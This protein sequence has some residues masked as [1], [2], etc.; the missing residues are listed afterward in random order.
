MSTLPCLPHQTLLLSAPNHTQVLTYTAITALSG[1]L[2]MRSP[3]NKRSVTS[4]CRPRILV[5]PSYVSASRIN[6]FSGGCGSEQIQ[7]HLKRWS[8][9]QLDVSSK[10]PGGKFVLAQLKTVHPLTRFMA[11]Y[12]WMRCWG[13]IPLLMEYS[14]QQTCVVSVG[15]CSVLGRLLR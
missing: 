15:S 8:L 13:E 2:A 11:S 3:N 5:Y 9:S 12:T 1:M 6:L 10:F 14:E 4:C 7:S